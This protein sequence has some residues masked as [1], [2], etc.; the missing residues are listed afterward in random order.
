MSFA[1]MKKNRGAAKTALSAKLKKRAEEENTGNRFVDDRYWTYKADEA[2][3][4][5]VTLRF[6][7]LW[8]GADDTQDEPWV[9]LYTHSFKGNGKWFIN[10]CPK[11][12]GMDTPCPVCEYNKSVTESHG[13]WDKLPSNIKQTLQS[14]GEVGRAKRT[15]YIANIMVVK[16]PTNPENNGKTFLWKFGP[17]VLG[18][19]LGAI[20]P[21]IDKD[22]PA[23]VDTAPL[24]PFDFWDGNNFVLRVRQ[25]DNRTSYLSSSFLDSTP[26]YDDDE[27]IESVW[28]GI[29]NL[30]ELVDASKIEEYAKLKTSMEAVLKLTP[31]KKDK[32]AAKTVDDKPAG[33]VAEEEDDDED[34]TPPFDMD[35]KTAEPNMGGVDD[36]DDFYADLLED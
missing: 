7:P 29:H 13:G 33:K 21:V 10:N 27:K 16:D 20:N 32:E 34:Y 6:L 15:Q 23:S 36:D 28:K 5:T 26:L 24:S 1:S 14:G 4:V 25:K 9:Q 30:N 35:D 12:L 3:S 22:D 31:S 17:Q 19:I 11:T 18:I 2:G 8:E